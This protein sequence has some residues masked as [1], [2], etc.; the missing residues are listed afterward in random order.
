[1]PERQRNADPSVETRSDSRVRNRTIVRFFTCYPILLGKTFSR[2]DLA[3][4][5][6]WNMKRNDV[7]LG[8]LKIFGH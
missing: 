8:V 5:R 2:A 1:M 7:I 3:G 4:A 6:E